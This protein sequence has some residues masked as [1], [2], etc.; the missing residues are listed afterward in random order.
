MSNGGVCGG[1]GLEPL[2]QLQRK[3]KKA[4]EMKKCE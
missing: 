2:L 3:R 1:M 4:R